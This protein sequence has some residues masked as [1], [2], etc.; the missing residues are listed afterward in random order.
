MKTHKLMFVFYPQSHLFI[1][2]FDFWCL[3]KSV[4]K[5]KQQHSV[6]QYHSVDLNLLIISM[7]MDFP[8][9]WTEHDVIFC[10]RHK[11]T[12]ASRLLFTKNKPESIKKKQERGRLYYGLHRTGSDP[13]IRKEETFT[14]SEWNPL[15][16]F[17]NHC[18]S[19]CTQERKASL[20]DCESL[21]HI[22][23]PE[24][25]SVSHQLLFFIQ[26]S[27]SKQILVIKVFQLW[28]EIWVFGW[29]TT[30]C[31][32]LSNL[33]LYFTRVIMSVAAVRM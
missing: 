24:L 14:C 4:I 6:S 20:C 12:T 26:L 8:S 32:A 16:S 7:L 31:S 30:S 22:C 2:I 5:K 11:L 18:F 10:Y 27:E 21:F 28:C 3:K 25:L 33:S 23:V 29:S 15:K 9:D 17:S 19:Q 1:L 13:T